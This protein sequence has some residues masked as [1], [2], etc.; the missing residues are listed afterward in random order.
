M[1][2]AK[3]FV[4]ATWQRCQFHVMKNLLDHAPKKE[5][6]NV[7][8]AARLIFLATDRKEAE[9]RYAEFMARFAETAP[10]SCVCLEGAFED[11]LAILPLPEKYRRR[12]RTSN[13]QERLNEEIRRREKVIRIFPNDAAAIRMVG[14]LLSEQNDECLSR[15]YFDMTEYF[16]WKATTVAKP[17]AVKRDRRSRIVSRPVVY[18]RVALV[19]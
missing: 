2:I 18:E 11:M 1:T 17:A 16:E 3:Q 12:L 5:R 14:A 8:A 19:A 6:E 15:A 13:M 9:R 7:T 10:K 4:G